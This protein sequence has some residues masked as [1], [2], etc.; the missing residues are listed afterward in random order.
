MRGILGQYIFIIPER[1]MVVV[2]LGHERS[3]ERLDGVP[4]DVYTY[5]EIANRI[6]D[7]AQ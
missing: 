1:E 2:R 3:D 5:L 4:T 7:E 6:A